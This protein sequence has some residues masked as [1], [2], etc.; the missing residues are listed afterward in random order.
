MSEARVAQ[1]ARDGR[2]LER[3]GRRL[4]SLVRRP[5]HSALERFLSRIR[6][7]HAKRHG[8]T[9]RSRSRDQTVRHGGR[10]E[11][12][13]RRRT[14]DQAAQADHRIESAGLGDM[15]APALV[16]AAVHTGLSEREAAATVASAG[17][18]R[19]APHG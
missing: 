12:E 1:A 18:L 15:L 10:D 3:R 17:R 8:D 13:V 4:P 16:T 5:F 6:R 7:Q 2:H 11:V 19:A 9:G 14:P